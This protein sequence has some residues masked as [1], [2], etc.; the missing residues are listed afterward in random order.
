MTKWYIKPALGNIVVEPQSEEERTAAGL[1]LV[2]PAVETETHIAEV[3]EVCD[4]YEAVAS[5]RSISRG[6]PIYSVGDLVIIGKYNGRDIKIRDDRTQPE[7]RFI[8]IRESDILGLLLHRAQTN[9]VNEQDT[10]DAEGIEIST[11]GR[12]E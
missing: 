6:G 12:V 11:S 4:E 10:G 1:W 9:G 5:D 2:G 7:K 3:V 8:I